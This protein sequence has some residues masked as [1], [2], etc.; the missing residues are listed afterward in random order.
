MSDRGKVYQIRKKW[1]TQNNSYT[2]RYCKYYDYTFLQKI[3][4]LYR[5]GKA[6]ESYNECVIML[7]TETS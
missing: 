1:M 2:F 3:M 7:V 4:K 5:S 6:H